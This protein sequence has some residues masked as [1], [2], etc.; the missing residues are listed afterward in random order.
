MPLSVMIVDGDEATRGRLRAILGGHADFSVVAEAGTVEDALHQM[1]TAC[2]DVVVMDAELMVGSGIDACEKIVGQQPDTKVIVLSSCAEDD[3]FLDA[4]A[5]GASG[6]LLKRSEDAEFV[7][8]L[9]GVVSGQGF[10]D[11]ALIP[12]VFERVRASV[13]DERR[14][15]FADLTEQEMRVLALIAEGMTNR[16]IAGALYL[17]EGTVRNHVGSILTKLDLCNRTASAAY[18][19]KHGIQKR[20]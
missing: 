8:A 17:G 11:P 6:Y 20:V 14:D 7:R 2:P 19:V 12:C 9:E 15:A 5:A 18:A 16:E 10:L 3:A 4:V 13:E 1:L